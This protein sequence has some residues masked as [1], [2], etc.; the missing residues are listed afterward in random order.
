MR[1]MAAV[2]YGFCTPGGHDGEGL[3]DTVE[4]FDPEQ[5]T[6]MVVTSLSSPRC[7]GGLVAMKG[8]LY[9]VG[10][11]DGASVLQSLQVSTYHTHCTHGHASH[12]PSSL[13]LSLSAIAPTMMSGSQWPLSPSN[14]VALAQ[15][16]WTTFSMSVEAA[17]TCQRCVS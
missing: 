11:Y 5:D 14:A 8:F 4:R 13:S 12:T 6:W 15:L 17:T 9:A 1:F 2:C 16:Y 10:G 7:L 3:L